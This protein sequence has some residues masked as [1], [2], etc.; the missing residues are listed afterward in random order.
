VRYKDL[1]TE[2]YTGDNK[3]LLDYMKAKTFDPYTCW[4]LVCYWIEENDY[5]DEV[6]AG[7]E[8]KPET[9]ADLQEEEAELFYR[10][11]PD[12]QNACA[13]WVIEQLMTDDPTATPTWAHMDLER[14]RLLPRTTW[15]VHFS[16]D[17]SDIARSGFT[18]GMDDMDR[19]GLTTWFKKESKTNGG[20]N[21]AFKAQSRYAIHA[22][23]QNKYGKHAVLFQNS[24]VLASHHAD[25][26]S[27]VMFWGKDVDY[28]DIIELRNNYGDWEVVSRRDGRVIRFG[29]FET[30][31]AWV[32][33]NFSQYRKAITGR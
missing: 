28:R 1:I 20:Y 7:I 16:N 14:D 25:E 29:N 15:L 31:V 27:Q 26:E 30:V 4:D 13:Q 9:R 21:F 6:S 19:L 32:I 11:S 33:N 10:L 8:P 22:A 24:G 17:A 3:S 2:R 23:N 5:I 12:D 18:H